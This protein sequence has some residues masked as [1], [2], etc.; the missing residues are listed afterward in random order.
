MQYVSP[1]ARFPSRITVLCP[2]KWVVTSYLFSSSNTG[3][4]SS[5][6]FNSID[7]LSDLASINTTKC[8]SLVKRDI[9]PFASRLSA[10]CAYASKSSRISKRSAASVSEIETCVPIKVRLLYVWIPLHITLIFS[11]N[12]DSS[13]TLIVWNIYPFFILDQCSYHNLLLNHK[14]FILFLIMHNWSFALEF[15]FDTT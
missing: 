12:I 10:Q 13:A 6:R 15:A 7:G 8:V 2:M 9:C 4:K 5:R 11:A 1:V 14:R 3:A